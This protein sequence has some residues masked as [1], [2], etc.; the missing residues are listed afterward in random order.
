MQHTDLLLPFY[1]RTLFESDVKRQVFFCASHTENRIE[2]T[3]KKSNP[4]P[5]PYFT[6]KS[7]YFTW[8]SL[9]FTKHLCNITST[10]PSNSTQQDSTV[11]QK[12]YD[13][14]KMK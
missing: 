4:H 1:H 9:Y 2:K 10:I 11:C 6:W 7:P 8:K 5:Y 12:N 13:L 3:T 14:K